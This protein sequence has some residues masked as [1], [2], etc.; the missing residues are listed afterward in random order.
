MLRGI[1][2]GVVEYCDAMQEDTNKRGREVASSECVLEL[3][4]GPGSTWQDRFYSKQ[5]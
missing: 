2:Y 1:M 3:M 4:W 5:L